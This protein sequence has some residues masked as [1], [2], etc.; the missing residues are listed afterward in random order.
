MMTELIREPIFL[1][2]LL[3]GLAF[4]F[5]GMRI[6]KK[7]IES[8]SWPSTL[9]KVTSSAITKEVK[10]THPHRGKSRYYTAKISYEYIVNGILHTATKICWGEYTSTRQ[11]AIQEIVS[12]YPVD[13]A[14]IVRYA[15]YKPELAILEPGPNWRCYFLLGL[16]VAL[17]VIGFLGIAGLIKR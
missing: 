13:K 4:T 10:T 2:P 17:A 8:E 7:A 12:R 15:P 11:N 3:P 6:L 5:L 9:G 1:I 16:G 14:V